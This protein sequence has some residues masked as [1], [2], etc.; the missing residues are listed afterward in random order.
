MDTRGI[1]VGAVARMASTLAAVEFFRDEYAID[2][3]TDFD[4]LN[5]DGTFSEAA[6]FTVWEMC[7][8]AG[9]LPPEKIERLNAGGQNIQDAAQCSF[10]VEFEYHPSRVY[11]DGRWWRVVEVSISHG[12]T[13]V[14]VSKIATDDPPPDEYTP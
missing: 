2:E 4:T 13:V 8:F 14:T 6:R 1:N 9:M 7:A 10:P 5:D 12:V 3:Y 11:V